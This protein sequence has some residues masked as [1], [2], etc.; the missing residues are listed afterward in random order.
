MLSDV[1]ASC[2]PDACPTDPPLLTGQ[3]RPL[4]AWRRR[5]Y[6]P[7]MVSAAL[8]P[9]LS[10]PGARTASRE[11]GHDRPMTPTQ[12]QRWRDGSL[13]TPPA[14]GERTGTWSLRP[15][16]REDKDGAVLPGLH[17]G[18]EIP[19]DPMGSSCTAVVAVR[20]LS[21]SPRRC[22]TSGQ[23]HACPESVPVRAVT[24]NRL[25]QWTRASGEQMKQPRR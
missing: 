4:M 3:W 25:S 23:L 12:R 21:K 8:Y 2:R 14:S 22:R 1:S 13:V 20:H 19:Q 15:A 7:F 5:A 16:T 18:G 11:R 6:G 17:L 24:A 9:H 10:G